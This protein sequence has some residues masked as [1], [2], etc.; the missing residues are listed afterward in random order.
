M[1]RIMSTAV[2]YLVLLQ[3]VPTIHV[4]V[5]RRSMEPTASDTHSRAHD[6]ASQAVTGVE[7]LQ[8]MAVALLEHTATFVD[9]LTTASPSNPIPSGM[10]TRYLSRVD[11]L[12]KLLNS[13]IGVLEEERTDLQPAGG[14]HGEELDTVLATSALDLLEGRMSHLLTQVDTAQAQLNR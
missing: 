12:Q 3:N 4:F 6:D 13:T 9:T 14:I 11:T 2:P 10:C 5:P 1:C 8:L 7:S